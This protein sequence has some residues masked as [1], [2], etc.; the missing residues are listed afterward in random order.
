M[1]NR[2]GQVGLPLIGGVVATAIGAGGV[3]AITA[4]GLFAAAAGVF[5]K[6][7]DLN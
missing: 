3:F 5:Q 4:V 6:R 2:V 7:R 1:G